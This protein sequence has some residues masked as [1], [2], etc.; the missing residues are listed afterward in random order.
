MADPQ[1]RGVAVQPRSSARGR[2]V[3][4]D[5]R[6]CQLGD[7]EDLNVR[8]QQPYAAARPGLRTRAERHAAC[9]CGAPAPRATAPE[10][11]HSIGV[12]LEQNRRGRRELVK[13]AHLARETQ[14]VDMQHVWG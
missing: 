2:L 13:L 3:S 8:R 12:V 4:G 9:S 7:L 14:A 5:K 1:Y 11:R 6:A 10:A